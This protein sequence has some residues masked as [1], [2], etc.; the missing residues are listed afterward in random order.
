MK[1]DGWV[2]NLETLRG[3]WRNDRE[4]V[5]GTIRTTSSAALIPTWPLPLLPN[6]N[7]LLPPT[8]P[9]PLSPPAPSPPTTP[10]LTALTPLQASPSTWL[11]PFSLS[12]SPGHLICSSP[13]PPPSSPTSPPL[14]PPLRLRL[15]PSSP[16]TAAS[17]SHIIW[18]IPPTSQSTSSRT[19]SMPT[20]A[21][22][23]TS[24][25]RVHSE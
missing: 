14:P 11:L 7:L 18:W 19:P 17:P 21:V 25:S 3:K 2:Q 9:L 10:F 4:L 15:H 5:N 12:P 13:L 6:P 1:N 20:N 22:A 24:G 23:C 16:I 8:A